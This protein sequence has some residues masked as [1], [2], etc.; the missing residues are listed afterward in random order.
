MKVKVHKKGIVV[1]PKEV[2]DR[3]KITEGSVLKIEIKGDEIVL[4]KEIS[5]LDAWGMFEGRADSE[6]ALELLKEM[7]RKEVEKENSY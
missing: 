3:L 2:R 4:R 5:L 6:E 1:L 7:R